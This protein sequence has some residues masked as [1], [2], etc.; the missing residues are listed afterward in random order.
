MESHGLVLLLELNETLVNLSKRN[1]FK[2]IKYLNDCGVSVQVKTKQLESRDIVDEIFGQLY[3][4]GREN[5]INTLKDI[6][7]EATNLKLKQKKWFKKQELIIEILNVVEM[8]L[9]SYQIQV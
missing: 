6:L 4:Q 8:H 3:D 2:W 5:N 7:E 9:I 1:L